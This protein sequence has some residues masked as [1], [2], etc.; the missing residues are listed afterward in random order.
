MQITNDTTSTFNILPQA[1][2]CELQFVQVDLNY[3]VSDSKEATD[4]LSDT[5]EKETI[6]VGLSEADVGKVKSFL[7][8]IRIF[9]NTGDT[10][11]GLYTLLNII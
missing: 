11:I 9:F 7:W 1:V 3:K 8:N 10:D 2:L 4:P 6:H 5:I